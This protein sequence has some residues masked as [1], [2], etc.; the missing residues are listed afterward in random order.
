[1]DTILALLNGV[2]QWGS[3]KGFYSRALQ[4]LE[5]HALQVS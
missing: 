3:I 1:M 5:A 4:Y 2:L